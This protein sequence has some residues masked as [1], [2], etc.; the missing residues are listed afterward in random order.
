[1]GE[2]FDIGKNWV[3]FAE[4]KIPSLEPGL[5]SIVMWGDDRPGLDP[6]TLLLEG[7]VLYGGVDNLQTKTREAVF[8]ELSETVHGQ[9]TKIALVYRAER[10][11]VQLYLDNVLVADSIC[12]FKPSI[13]RPMPVRVGG[14]WGTAQRFRGQLRNLA[15]ANFD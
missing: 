15:I 8:V 14:A 5:H 10:N 9:W 2:R 7:K 4:T 12:S 11:V 13:D 3:V 6:I 1:M